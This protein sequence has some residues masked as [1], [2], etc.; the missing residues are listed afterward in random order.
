M[1]NKTTIK[2]QFSKYIKWFWIAILGGTFAI[3]L[4]FLLASWGVFGALPSFEELENPEK[5][6]ASEVISIDGKTLGKYFKENRTPVKYKGSL[7]TFSKIYRIL[8]IFYNGAELENQEPFNMV[9]LGQSLGNKR[10]V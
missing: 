6:L 8:I 5:N 10:K 2:N 4:V 9:I 7:K 3:I 1:T